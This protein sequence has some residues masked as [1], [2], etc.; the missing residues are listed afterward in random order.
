[1]FWDLEPFGSKEGETDVYGEFMKGI[2]FKGNRYKVTLPWQEFH[3]ILPSHQELYVKRSTGLFRCLQQTPELLQQ[4]DT[5]IKDQLKREIVEVVD[6]TERHNNLI[7]Y[8]PH[9]PVVREDKTMTKLRIDYDALTKT[10][11]PSLYD[12]LYARPKFGQSIMDILLRFRI[13][14]TALATDIEKHF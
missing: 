5:V 8:L 11:G 9:H 7:H 1:M 14:K 13:H 10:C 4:Y 6:D 12:C 3:L 2:Y